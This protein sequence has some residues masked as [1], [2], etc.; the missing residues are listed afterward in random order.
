MTLKVTHW[1]ECESGGKRGDAPSR[2]HPLLKA[3]GI[4]LHHVDVSKGEKRDA[5]LVGSAEAVAASW[6]KRAGLLHGRRDAVGQRRVEAPSAVTAVK[7]LRACVL[8]A[9]ARVGQ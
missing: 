6:A 3:G 5:R 1:V 4:N 9:E 8:G 2:G 7:P